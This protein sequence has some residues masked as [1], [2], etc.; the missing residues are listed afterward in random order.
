MADEK[1]QSGIASG[2]LI[3]RVSGAAERAGVRAG[4]VLLAIDGR[5]VTSLAEA[6]TAVARS[7]KSMALL[8]QRGELKIYVP[9]RLV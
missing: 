1:R 8:L 3:E 7:D 6:S 5:P 4:D 2:L 9:V